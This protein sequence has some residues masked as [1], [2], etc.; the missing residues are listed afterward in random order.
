M[1]KCFVHDNYG[2]DHSFDECSFFVKTE[3]VF[4]YKIA[5]SDDI[6]AYFPSLIF[7]KIV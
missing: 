5:D 4:I 2:I 6:V 3:G 1:S 7:V